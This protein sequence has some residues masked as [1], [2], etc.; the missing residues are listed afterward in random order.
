MDPG[1]AADEEGGEVRGEAS[2]GREDAAGDGLAPPDVEVVQPGQVRHQLDE[3]EVGEA[4][5]RETELVEA[6]V[7]PGGL[8]QTLLTDKTSPAVREVE[9]PQVGTLEAMA[10]AEAGD[11]GPTE[12]E[13]PQSVQLVDT[14]GGLAG[15]TG[16][17]LISTHQLHGIVLS[18][19]LQ[20]HFDLGSRKEK[21]IHI[22]STKILP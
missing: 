12:V 4:G 1:A 16:T 10:E 14:P 21:V 20:D 6:R 19:S 22:S 2:E 18:L 8:G 11:G 7:R 3:S 9:G 5:G 17:L 13:V 15:R